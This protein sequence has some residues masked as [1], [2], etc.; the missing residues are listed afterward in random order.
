MN[1]KLPIR[2][3]SEK[4]KAKSVLLREVN[5]TAWLRDKNCIVCHSTDI[6]GEPFSSG[7]HHLLSRGIAPKEY[8]SEKNILLL[9]IRHHNSD[10]DTIPVRRKLITLMAKNHPEYDYNV[11]PYQWYLDISIDLYKENE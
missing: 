7:G 3:V 10:A 9:C 6:F 5:R 1:A 4:Q 2:R 8:L 11:Q